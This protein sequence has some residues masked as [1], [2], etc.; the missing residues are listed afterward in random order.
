M[1]PDYERVA[2]EILHRHYCECLG[3]A[4]ETDTRAAR[5]VVKA[6]LQMTGAAPGWKPSRFARW[7]RR[8]AA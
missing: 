7:R 5:A 4:H 6:L 2:A 3:T 8:A 1:K